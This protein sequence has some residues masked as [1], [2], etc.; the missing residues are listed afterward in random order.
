MNQEYL[1]KIIRQAVYLEGLKAGEAENFKKVAKAVDEYLSDNAYNIEISTLSIAKLNELL[2]KLDK[3]ISKIY[4]G[5]TQSLLTTIK[6]VYSH[7]YQL[8]ARTLASSFEGVAMIGSAGTTP[9]AITNEPP[10]PKSSPTKTP[11]VLDNKAVLLNDLL[12]DFTQNESKA[13]ID[14]LRASHFNG[15]SV[16]EMI[17]KIRGTK[18]NNYKDGLLD[19]SRRRAE[20]LARTGIQHAAITARQEFG[21]A[22]SDIIESKQFISVLDSRTSK[23]CQAIDHRIVPLDS[24]LNPPF[25][26]N[27]RTSVVFILKK[28]FRGD[29]S[30]NKRRAGKERIDAKMSYYDWLLTQSKEFQDD[31]LGKTRAKLLRD[32]GLSAEQFAKLS[33]DKNFNPLTLKQMK[34]KNPLI[35]EKA[36]L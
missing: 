6:E 31:V 1:D 27:C 10:S 4:S 30:G 13:V 33:L 8:E 21:N 7:S 16:P 36:G 29:E 11:I 25:H 17:K 3:G 12:E 28:E 26:I 20:A 34:A 32:G 18:A 22:N 15:D 24:P 14:T 19:T 23:Q 9:A 2:A 5:Y 35:F